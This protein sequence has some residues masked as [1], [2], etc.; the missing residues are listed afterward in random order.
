MRNDR[1]ETEQP[2]PVDAAAERLTFADAVRIRREA[3]IAE[4]ALPRLLT[5]GRDTGR[6]VATM[7][8][9]LDITESYAHRLIREYRAAQQ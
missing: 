9:E 5:E 2:D 4:R 6:R 8:A 7:A 1:D 3:P